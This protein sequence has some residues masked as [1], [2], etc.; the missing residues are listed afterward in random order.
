MEKDRLRFT[1]GRF[2]HYYDSVNNKG[3]I[4][5]GLATFIVGGLIAGYPALS[6]KI[7][8]TFWIHANWAILI[9]LGL[10]AMLLMIVASTPHLTS[11]SN[12]VFYFLSIS[13]MGR[14][15]FTDRSKELSEDQELDD[16]RSQ[17]FF[18][19]RG[20]TGKFRKL[21]AASRLIALQFIL[22][23]PFII[24]LIKYLK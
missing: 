14:T 19:A 23:V 4:I 21:R 17:A 15:G 24:L 22:F 8:C 20:L 6:E 12:S 2:D 16:L 11:G 18:L 5:L 1:I 3:N 7:E 9:A 10:A 13:K